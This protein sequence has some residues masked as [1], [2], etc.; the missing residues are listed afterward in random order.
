ML[1]A[2]SSSI[3]SIDRLL[4]DIECEIANANIITKRAEN[5]LWALCGFLALYAVIALTWL[6]SKK[7]TRESKPATGLDVLMAVYT[8][9]LITMFVEFI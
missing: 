4:I 1:Q 2:S 7:L 6:D 5:R 8:S 3:D 9:A